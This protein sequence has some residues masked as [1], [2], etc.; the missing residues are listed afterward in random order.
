MNS[1]KFA[2]LM[3]YVSVGLIA[4]SL[5]VSYLTTEVFSL[6]SEIA[7]WCEKIAYYLACLSTIICA[8]SYAT[9]KRSG[10]YMMFLVVFVVVIILFTFII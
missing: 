5:V 1:R 2:N 10:I 4:L 3:A 6:T 8:F 9:A 7:Y